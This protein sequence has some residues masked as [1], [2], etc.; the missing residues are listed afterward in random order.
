MAFLNRF[1][2]SLCARLVLAVSTVLSLCCSRSE[3]GSSREGRPNVLWIVWDTVR[4]DHL[5]LYGYGKRTTPHLNE[6]ARRACVFEDCIAAA[7][8]T[9]PSHASMFTGLLP[10]EHGANNDYPFLAG[11]WKTVAELF[12]ENG[13]ETYLYSANPHISSAENFHQGYDVEEHPWD[14]KYWSD[15]LGIVR[16]KV[17]P[18]DRSSE[19]GASLRAG[20]LGIWDV[21]ASGELAQRGLEAWLQGRDPQRPFFAFLNYMEAHRPTIPPHRYRERMMDAEHVAR[22]YA[23]DRSWDP[24]WRYT[25]GLHEYSREELEILAD[26][27]DATLAELDDL[28]HALIT[29][30]GAKGYLDNTVVILT[31]DHGEHLGEHHMLDHQYS[32]YNPLLRVPLV[33]HYPKRFASGRDRRPVVTFDLFP[34]LLELA[35]IEAP[36]GLSTQA[37][38]LCSAPA[39]RVRLAEYRA[40]FREPF[41]RIRQSHP[42]WDSGR[43]ERGLRAYFDGPYKYIRASDGQDELYHIV[44]DPGEGRNLVSQES[45]V[46]AR[47]TAGLEAYVGRLRTGAAVAKEPRPK[48]SEQ[49][50]RLLNAVGYVHMPEAS[51]SASRPATGPTTQT[52]RMPPP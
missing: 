21:K 19:L 6:W 13:Y 31:S 32:V 48:M 27:Y 35:E 43:W 28:F 5:S 36:S 23:V 52:H 51:D 9:V 8:Y 29:S 37:C 50:R 22:S 26:T 14:R 18:D 46:A 30:L 49:Q 33:I 45:A 39:S 20:R 17:R 16:K 38:S 11:G 47:L 15:A 7:S 41:A 10:S 40:P 44:D 34:T 24:I 4:A 25:F 42:Q 1:D 12:R 2:R 3:E